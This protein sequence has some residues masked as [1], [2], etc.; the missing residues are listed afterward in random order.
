[1]KV[2]GSEA[3]VKTLEALGV[4][5]MFGLPGD[6]THMYD[7]MVRT[8]AIRHVLVRHEQCAGHM[9]DGYARAT[10][11]VGVCDAA[12]GPGATNLVT[13][14]AE[15]YT[16][17]IPVVAIVSNIR[18]DQ[19]GRG[20][21]QE[22]DQLSILAP[23]TK[24]CIDAQVASRIPEYVRR[25]FQ[26]AVTGKPGPVVLNFPLE[27]FRENIEP[28][29]AEFT[30]LARWGVWP[31]LRQRADESVV[32]SALELL[33]S[34]QRPLIWCGGGVLSSGAWEGVEKLALLTGI[35]VT[36]TFMGKGSLREDHPLC[37]GPA[38]LLGRSAA[39]DYIR[40]ADVI[41]ALGTRFSNLD[42]AQGTLPSKH[43]RVIQVD[44]DPFEL[45]RNVRAEV[46]VLSDLRQFLQDFERLCSA[47][48]V[49]HIGSQTQAEIE[50]I[51]QT[52]R[53]ERGAMSTKSEIT[54]TTQV[55]PLQVI[56]A[57]RETMGDKD[58][59][60]CDSGFNQIWGGQYF[61]VD[62]PGRS[63]IAP[64]GFG[65]M[66]YAL[67][68]A[69]GAKMGAPEKTFVALCGDGGFAMVMQEL[70]T[71]VRVKAPIVVVVMNN[72]NLEYIK[73]GQRSFFEGRFISVDFTDVD[74]AAVARALGCHGVRITDARDLH[75]ALTDALKS[76]VTTVIDVVTLESAEP[77]RVVIAR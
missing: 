65:T 46:C 50:A 1:M 21:F 36:T 44:I 63:Y 7:A 77:D 23:V 19:R 57:M 51:A 29:E 49:G 73:Q 47:K 58:V 41:L 38:G 30:G 17:G 18:K 31:A 56:R 13:S 3:L 10:G 61:E 14:I 62:R 48:G 4:E 34:G 67:P 15:A 26:I 8:T 28:Q 68:A 12:N 27:V 69:I 24:A 25:A 33:Q 54:Q 11:K 37:L 42:T 2:S 35:P 76:Q 53:T 70:E 66:G 59:I 43:A 22:V 74:H 71:S 64:R 55:H 40:Q 75:R 39:N 20:I 16:D 72:R 60:V 9:A 52:W 45:D 6:H 5:V 32:Q